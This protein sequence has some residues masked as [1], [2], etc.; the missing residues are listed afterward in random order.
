MPS[1]AT[2]MSHSSARWNE[3]PITQPLQA[4]ITGASS[5][6]SCWMPRWPR[7]ISSW[8]ESGDLQVADR[9]DV[10]ARRE[11]L[12]LA[13]PDHR[14]HVGRAPA[15]RRGSSKSCRVHVVVERVV[16]LG[17]VVGDGRDRAVDRQSHPVRHVLDSPVARAPGGAVHGWIV[18]R[19]SGPGRHATHRDCDRGSARVGTRI[20]R[21]PHSLDQD[22]AEDG[23]AEEREVGDAEDPRDGE[24]A[25]PGVAAD[26]GRR[27]TGRAARASRTRTSRTPRRRRRV[28]TTGVCIAIASVAATMPR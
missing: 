13:P 18:T 20:A 12:A 28:R 27:A 17:V 5:S 25:G 11:R 9:A 1:A 24:L 23:A 21:L 15:A 8:C 2:R 10:A 7:R 14:P 3:P 19:R 4:T 26:R 22:P 6:Q 16:L